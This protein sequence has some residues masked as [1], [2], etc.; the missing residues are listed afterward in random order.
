ME[1]AIDESPLRKGNYL[2][3]RVR[4]VGFYITNLKRS[5]E[6]YFPE[7]RYVYFAR[8]ES[9]PKEA[10]LVH[11]PYF[12][13]FFVTL[14]VRKLHKTV[15]TIHDLIPFVFPK[16]FPS[17]IRGKLKWEFQKTLLRRSDAIITD[18][19]SS[20]K[21]IIRYTNI[22]EEKIKVVYLA[23][24]EEFKKVQ[25][26]IRQPRFNRGQLADKV[27]GF[28][29]KYNLP[30]KFA[31]YVGD[32]TWNKNLPKLIRAIET[33]GIPLVMVGK[34][35][36]EKDFDK[37]NPWNQDLAK[38]QELIEGNKNIIRLGFVSTE[39]LVGLYNLATVFVMPSLYEGFGLPILEAMIC[40]CPV[41]TTREGSL[42]EV[43]GEAA[44]YVNAKDT[45]SIAR[46]VRDVFTNTKI[47]KDLSQKGL[48]WVKNFSWK[49][50][51]E[52]TV[53]VYKSI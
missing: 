43:A 20:K 53:Q 50:T 48:S 37:T 31:L 4:G 30:D 19:Q 16:Y 26:S 7:N 46:G 22:P 35:L 17:G 6:K 15:V 49:K 44:Y 21:D 42:P 10:D 33:I 32:V 11:I 3:H 1:I 5:L 52:K 23:A 27:Q 51:I 39:D 47:Q 18:S 9:I 29:Q 40:G 36:I 41:V 45:E 34:A 2:K 13:P 38:A 8:P 12:E 28:R 14:P 24:G 25:G